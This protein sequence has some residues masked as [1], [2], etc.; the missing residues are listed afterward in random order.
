MKTIYNTPYPIS[1]LRNSRFSIFLRWDLPDEVLSQVFQ[2]FYWK[3]YLS[4]GE[5][6]PSCFFMCDIESEVFV[7]E[8]SLKPF[9]QQVFSFLENHSVCGLVCHPE[10]DWTEVPLRTWSQTDS[11][12]VH[13]INEYS[14]VGEYDTPFP[15]PVDDDVNFFRRV[16]APENNLGIRGIYSEILTDEQ[17]DIWKSDFEYAER[18]GEY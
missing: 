8:E 1:D 4:E 16:S 18:R 5:N 15:N 3:E 10:H 17:F 13:I 14:Y 9:V 11:R 12:S 7:G 2:D 6:N